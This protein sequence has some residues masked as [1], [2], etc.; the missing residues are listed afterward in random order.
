MQLETK[1]CQRVTKSVNLF[2]ASL[3]Q[4]KSSLV[5]ISLPLT[6]A[7]ASINLK[8]FGSNNNPFYF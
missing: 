3:E 7:R 5:E 4:Q 2:I 8:P 6:L 1:V